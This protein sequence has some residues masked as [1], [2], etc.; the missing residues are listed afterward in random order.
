MHECEAITEAAMFDGDVP[1][2]LEEVM[3]DPS[4]V[5]HVRARWIDSDSLDTFLDP[6]NAHLTVEGYPAPVRAVVVATTA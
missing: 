2:L 4:R 1:V 5:Q 6:D 3:G